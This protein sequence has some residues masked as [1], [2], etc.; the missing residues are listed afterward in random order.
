MQIRNWVLVSTMLC[1][2]VSGCGS[3]RSN[4]GDQNKLQTEEENF[5]Q[6]CT[7]FPEARECVDIDNEATALGFNDYFGSGNDFFSDN[8]FGNS[9]MG[10][11][12]RHGERP[13]FYRG[14]PKCEN[15]QIYQ[16]VQSTQVSMRYVSRPDGREKLW[17]AF[18]TTTVV[19]SESRGFDSS[20]SCSADFGARCNPERGNTDCR[21]MKDQNGQPLATQCLSMDETQYGTCAPFEA[22]L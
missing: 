15:T 10:C 13:V 21:G 7:E 16:R 18:E 22:S 8:A 5:L 19:E 3:S 14:V 4:S 12:C 11:G 2:L 9:G 17:V 6:F 20:A 1:L